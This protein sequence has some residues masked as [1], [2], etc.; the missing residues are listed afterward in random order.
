MCA[1]VRYLPLILFGASAGWL[2]LTLRN[3]SVPDLAQVLG[4]RETFYLSD[5]RY[6]P[7][8]IYDFEIKN[9]V[10]DFTFVSDINGG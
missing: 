1:L 7:D 5:Y 3:A 10:F 9:G 8:W 6:V 2:T 4:E